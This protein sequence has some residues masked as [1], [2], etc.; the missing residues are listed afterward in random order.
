MDRTPMLFVR[1][2]GWVDDDD[3]DLPRRGYGYRAGMTEQELKDSTRAWWALS[4]ARAARYRYAAAV[5]DGHVVGVFGIVNG[6]WRSIDGRRL[7]RSTRRWAFD[8]E[9]A[10]DDMWRRIVGQRVPDRPDGGRLF[11]SG[12]VIAYWPE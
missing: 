9:D 12:S 8:V 11:G 1:L 5:A 3:R 4:A 7:G 6:S 2:T 10:P